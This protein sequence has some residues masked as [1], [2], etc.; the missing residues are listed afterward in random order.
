LIDSAH[1]EGNEMTETSGPDLT[2][3]PPAFAPPVAGRKQTYAEWQAEQ[4]PWG[5]RPPGAT[6]G[7][8]RPTTGMKSVTALGRWTQIMLFVQARTISGAA[9]AGQ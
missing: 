4:D 7:Y 8:P 9:R 1:R 2:K 5:A 6:S 3:N